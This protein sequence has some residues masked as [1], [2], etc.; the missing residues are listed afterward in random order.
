MLGELGSYRLLA[1]DTA[2][3][4]VIVTGLSERNV[5]DTISRL[6]TTEIVVALGTLLLAGLA[7]AFVVRRELRPLER[8]AVTAA[9]VSTLPLDRGE[10]SLA[11]RVPD[12]DPNTEV[13]QV[14]TALNRMLDHVGSALAARQDSETRLRPVRGRRQPR[15]A[16]PL[17]ALRATRS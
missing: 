14:G 4:G 7:G 6:R 15:A 11:E 3:R 8:V 12:V 9:R 16:H 10:V 5:E 1:T 17:A 13:G 2:T